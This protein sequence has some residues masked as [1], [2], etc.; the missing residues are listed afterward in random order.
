MCDNFKNKDG[1]SYDLIRSQEHIAN[2]NRHWETVRHMSNIQ[3]ATLP[4]WYFLNSKEELF[5]AITLLLI[6]SAIIIIFCVMMARYRFLIHRAY[7]SM[8]GGR[9][10]KKSYYRANFWERQHTLKIANLLPTLCILTNLSL[11][12]YTLC[13]S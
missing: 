2:Q 5:F 8:N 6:S 9:I 7:G 13:F 3:V 1:P 4:A 10:F 12:V 11:L